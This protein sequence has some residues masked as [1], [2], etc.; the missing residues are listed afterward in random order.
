MTIDAV[1]PWVDGNDPVLNSKRSQYT[2][3]KTVS[4]VDEASPTRFANLGEIF[5]CIASLNRFAK[6]LNKIYIVT[7][8][9]NPDLEPFLQKYFPDGWIPYEIVDHKVIYEGYEEYLPVFNSISIESMLWRIPGLSEHYLLLNDDFFLT[10]EAAPEDFYTSDGKVICYADKFSILVG[11]ILY[12]LK[13]SHGGHKVASYK[14][15]MLNA[16]KIAGKK[17]CFFYLR[18]TPRPL[19]KSFFE[20]FYAA[21]P[22]LLVRNISHKF[23]HAEQYSE[24]ELMYLMLSK[25]D[26][27]RVIPTPKVAFFLQPKPK[28]NYVAK[29]IEKLS[30]GDFKFCCFNSMDLA[31]EEDRELMK[32]WARE[33]LG[34]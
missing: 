22:D 4:H 29:M 21:D 8:G 14:H 31:S 33:R 30:N 9:Q 11:K 16:A 17:G 19:L 20:A 23:R 3:E 13:P 2:D 5:L 12:A 28:K 27:C 34:L 25:E 32:S 7:D 15:F 6:F 24:Q 1:I 18:H 10:R 26:R